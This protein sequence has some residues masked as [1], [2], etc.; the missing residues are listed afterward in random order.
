[1]IAIAT[2]P[3]N[4]TALSGVFGNVLAGLALVI[5]LRSLYIS[6]RT[7]RRAIDAEKV[8]AWIELFATGSLEWLVAKLSV[9]NPSRNDIKVQ[10][11]AIE[12]P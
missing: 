4:R 1:M 9:K 5:S 2:A 3:W 11:I 8:T 7:E 6:K 12:L 10:K